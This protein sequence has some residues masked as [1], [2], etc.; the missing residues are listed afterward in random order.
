[1][2]KLFL[3]MMTLFIMCF[4]LSAPSSANIEGGY[5]GNDPTTPDVVWNFIKHFNYEQFYWACDHQFTHNNNNRV[6]AMNFAYYCGHGAPWTIGYYSNCAGSGSSSYID[7]STAGSSSHRGYG[8]TN[9]NFIVFHSCKVVPSPIETNNWW[10]NWVSEPDDIFDGLHM[11]L[12]FRTSALIATATGIADFYG[13][14]MAGVN[15]VLWS[16]FDAIDARGDHS[17]GYDYGCAVMY[18]PAEDDKYNGTMVADPSENET[19]LKV[20][21][22]D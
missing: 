11:V 14:R 9:L 18:P 8:D 19:W 10:Q 12:G 4:S 16:W 20:W 13:S 22:Q 21:Y 7:L 15:Y 5:C 2:K 17:S 6:D 1:M 3:V